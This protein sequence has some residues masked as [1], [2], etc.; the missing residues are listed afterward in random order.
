MG[1]KNPFD[2]SFGTKTEYAIREFQGDNNL[3]VTG[4]VDSGTAKKLFGL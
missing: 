3:P 2:G 4:V 1:N